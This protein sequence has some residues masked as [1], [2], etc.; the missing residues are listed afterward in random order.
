MINK[1]KVI[2][3]FFAVGTSVFS[4]AVGAEDHIKGKGDS[5]NRPYQLTE[6]RQP[7]ADYAPHRRAFFG[8]THVHTAY[9]FDANTQDTRN[10]PADAYRFAKG[11]RMDI[12]PYDADGNGLR[13][14]QLDRPLDFTAISD[15]SEFLGEISIC[16]TP[17]T[18]SYWH[19]VCFANRHNAFLGTLAYGG[20]G[21]TMK[22]R[23]GFCGDDD[24]N[25]MAA[26]GS[27]WQKIQRDAEEAYDRTDA[28]SFTSF[29][30]YEWTASVGTGKNLHR[31]VI[32]RNHTVP[33]LPASWLDTPS[34][35]DLWDHLE[36]GCVQGVPGCDVL[37]IPHNSNLSGG[38]MFETARVAVD[39]IPQ[40]P[41]DAEEARR[42]ARWEPIFEVMQHKG[43]SECSL[44]AG[45]TEDEF[46]GFEDLPYDNFGGQKSVE[47]GTLTSILE[48]LMGEGYEMESTTPTRPSF[49][50]W[51]LTK[52]LQQQ[53]ELGV[54]PFKF[55][56][57]ASTDTH[58]AAPGLTAET[59]HPGHGGA[60]GLGTA[61]GL[62][63]GLND[64]IEFGPG[65][66]AVLWAEENTRDSLFAAMQR[67]ESYGT[68]GNR[69]EVRFFG[70]WNY[71][72]DLCED[73]AFVKKG[74]AEGVPMGSDLPGRS[75]EAP[76]FAV[77]ALKDPSPGTDLQRI[78]LIK[79]WLE[80]GEMKEQ[81]LDVAGGDNGAS[82][83]INTCQQSGKGATQLCSVWT[84]PDFNADE[85]A[86]YYA[87]IIENPSCRWSQHACN[88]ANVDCSKPNTVPEEMAAC[89]ASDHRP[90]IQE[91]A[92]TSPIW[93]TP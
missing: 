78:Q 11:E 13:S 12:Q 41:V 6:E 45:W 82:V 76:V 2:T 48:W 29:V 40:D 24:Q 9:S 50:R 15:H 90:A 92:W 56:V 72:K 65:G 93:Y 49:M 22:K 68:S 87:R 62:V 27:V 18:W 26:A 34:A 10:T 71:P 1:N 85:P 46:C 60:A 57:I 91:R 42:R 74:Y 88:A 63:V 20:M 84:D 61:D 43:A 73:T 36:Q 33:A 77:S 69:P 17:G 47:S 59:N 21:L 83:N 3:T 80:N 28:C 86:F 67:R 7:C 4:Y 89:C 66:L 16:R 25:C 30:G 23:W 19:P 32:F 58:I 75:S 37:T 51:A 64:Q 14:I 55:G 81:V 35:A 8:D 31:N 5:V 39:E 70:G 52:G 38:L 44:Y 53:Q 79:G 54:N